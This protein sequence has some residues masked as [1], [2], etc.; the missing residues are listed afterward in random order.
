MKKTISKVKHTIIYITLIVF[1]ILTTMCDTSDEGSQ[2]GKWTSV[3]LD[4]LTVYELN[5]S[6]GYIYSSTGNAGLFRY[7]LK[8]Q[9]NWTFLNIENDES[10]YGFVTS[11]VDEVNSLIYVGYYDPSRSAT[12]VYKSEDNGNTW[13]GFDQGLD[14]PEFENNAWSLRFISENGSSDQIYLGTEIGLFKISNGQNSWSFIEG[15]ENWGGQN[16][17]QALNIN[18][19]NSEI[20]V[21]GNTGRD[22]P[23]LVSSSLDNFDWIVNE[24]IYSVLSTTDFVYDIVFNSEDIIFACTQSGVIKSENNGDNWSLVKQLG[25]DSRQFDNFCTSIRIN[26]NN[27]SEILIGGKGLFHSFDSGN[28]WTKIGDAEVTSISDLYVD[29]ESNTAYASSLNPQKGVFKIKFKK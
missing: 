8:E 14:V 22:T 20:W 25:S 4:G 27:D 7:S 6:N 26:P 3:G 29:W 23:L 9:N 10:S 28:S 18:T 21:G 17:F 13:Q 5:Y 12:S 2:V 24:N 19:N 15:T 16:G 11:H 1:L